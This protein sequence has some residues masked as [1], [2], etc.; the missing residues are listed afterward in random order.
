MNK[1]NYL[2]YTTLNSFQKLCIHDTGD[3]S[4]V[5]AASN[6][7]FPYDNYLD[8]RRKKSKSRKKIK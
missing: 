6:H 3:S 5:W 4:A 8:I 7:A 2:S 1:R